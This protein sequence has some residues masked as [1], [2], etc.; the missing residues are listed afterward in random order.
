LQAGAPRL[1]AK[2]MAANVIRN[3]GE[4]KDIEKKVPRECRI[5]PIP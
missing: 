2:M 4:A 3:F 1:T 5:R